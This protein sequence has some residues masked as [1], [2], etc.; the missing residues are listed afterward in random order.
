MIWRL[1]AKL[2]AY[3]YLVNHL[4]YVPIYIHCDECDSA[5]AKEESDHADV[6]GKLCLRCFA[7]MT[8]QEYSWHNKPWWAVN[9]GKY[10]EG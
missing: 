4:E 3:Q 1:T 6:L 8:D 5:L 9:G 2:L 7:D 10:V